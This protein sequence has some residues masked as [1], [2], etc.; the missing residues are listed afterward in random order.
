MTGVSQFEGFGEDALDFYLGLA[1]DNSRTY[2]QARRPRYE[3]AVAEP[4]R[5]L[6]RELEPVY[7]T[8]KIF[9]P[10]RDVRF[11]SDK[12]PYKEAAGM[13]ADGIGGGALYLELGMPGLMIAG[14]YYV[15]ARDQLDRWRRLQDEPAVVRELDA[16]LDAL[17]TDGYRL[18]EGDPVRTAP[19]GWS[20]EHPRIDLIRRRRLE[21]FAQ[22]PPE[23]WLHT[24]EC[25]DVVRRGFDVL[26]RWNAWL[27]RRVG[28]ST[29][30]LG[31]AR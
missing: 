21:A 12:R 20:R 8:F 5:A 30:A 11:S 3:S 22:H 24:R 15:P 31:P 17:A 26:Q 1:A 29:E 28:P 13:V 27:G 18:G 25:L 2:W 10:Y 7:G 9:R 4:M 23:E 6:A 16:T 14:G 19:R